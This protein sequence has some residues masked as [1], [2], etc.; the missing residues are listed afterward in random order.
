MPRRSFVQT[1][2]NRWKRVLKIAGEAGTVAM[3]LRDRPRALDWIG[4][5]L[6]AVGI[7]LSVRDERRRAESRDP[8]RYFSDVAGVAW[9][10]VP[11]EFRRLV[12]ENIASPVI[13]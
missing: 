7:A 12:M 10:E 4:V 13:D 6:R 3:A 2:S 5:G 9:T 1:R 8:W 11:D